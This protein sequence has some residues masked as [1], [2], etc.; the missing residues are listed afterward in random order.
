MVAN[1]RRAAMF[2]GLAAASAILCLV[3]CLMLPVAVLLLPTMAAVLIV[4]EAFHTLAL[5]M[6]VP[7]SGLA[8]AIGFRRHRWT[9]PAAIVVPGLL[10]MAAALAWA[11]TDAWERAFT[12]LGSALLVAGHML[13]WAALQRRTRR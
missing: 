4:P 12:V 1:S 2:D 13:N 3:H 9:R 10:L 7:T 11:P 6:A 5:T 8:L